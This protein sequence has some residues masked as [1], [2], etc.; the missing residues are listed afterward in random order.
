MQDYAAA[1]RHMVDSQ[2]LP[3][4]VTDERVIDAMGLVPRENFVPPALKG[5]AY[6]DEDLEIA[7]GRFLLEPQV[8]ARMI[9]AA[10]IEPT[11][12]VLEI[13]CSTGYASAVLA[14]LAESVVAVESDPH[15]IETANKML[16][17]MDITNVAVV[18]GKLDGDYSRQG[19]FDVVFVN[20]AVEVTPESWTKALAEGGRL[21]YV[22]ATN[23]V[24]KAVLYTKVA[25]VPGRRF[26]FDAR[27]PVLPGFKRAAAF[28]F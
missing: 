21:V 10:E 14:H 25:G 28:V 2:I 4:R 6:I 17:A 9:Q 13:G 12:A 7:P 11:D 5:V 16:A 23:G 1:R 22:E 8:L 3:N 15:L 19:P 26:L 18:E 27:T 24:G 20:G